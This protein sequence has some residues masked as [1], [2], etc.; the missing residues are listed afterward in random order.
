MDRL[1]LRPVQVRLGYAG[2]ALG[3]QSTKEEESVNHP[4]NPTAKQ[5]T[6]LF[7]KAVQGDDVAMHDYFCC[8]LAAK[9]VAV[10]RH[11]HDVDRFLR[12]RERGA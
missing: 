7:V 6:E 11:Q 1:P 4:E 9:H 10:S 2:L 8:L 12:S 3:S 5:L